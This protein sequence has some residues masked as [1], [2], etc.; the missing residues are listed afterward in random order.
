M[1]TRVE[2]ATVQIMVTAHATLS[3]GPVH[4]MLS[5]RE[6]PAPRTWRYNLGDGQNSRIQYGRV[7]GKADHMEVLRYAAVMCRDVY[8][9][10]TIERGLLEQFAG[11]G[12]HEHPWPSGK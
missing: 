6:G 9:P 12:E 4:L 11:T 10:G 2:G 7:A 3:A 8:E 1:S 5:A